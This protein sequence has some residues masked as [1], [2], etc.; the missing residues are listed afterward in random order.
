MIEQSTTIKN[1]TGLHARPATQFISFLK[2]FTGTQI[3]LISNGKS[4]NPKSILNLLSLGL[5]CGSE[6]TVRVE[7]ENEVEILKEIIDFI[8]NLA[9]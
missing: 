9:E 2:K 1:P 4:A 8:D 6:V 5:T 3:T 7:G